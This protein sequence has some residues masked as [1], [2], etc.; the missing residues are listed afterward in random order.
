MPRRKERF[1]WLHAKQ[2][3]L[4]IA[5]AI[6]QA[7]IEFMKS[8]NLSAHTLNSCVNSQE[9][10]DRLWL[11]C[12]NIEERHVATEFNNRFLNYI[13]K[14]PL[15]MGH[16][17]LKVKRQVNLPTP[18]IR[19]PFGQSP[20]TDIGLHVVNDEWNGTLITFSYYSGR[21]FHIPHLQPIHIEKLMEEIQN[22]WK[23]EVCNC[24]QVVS[25]CCTHGCYT[26]FQLE[27]S[28][29]CGTGWKDFYLWKK[30]GYQIDY[31]S[32]F[33]IAKF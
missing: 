4:S 7:N 26:C 18:L 23:L 5:N 8:L 29:C 2:L 14:L 28:K 6:S 32:R 33:P 16:P 10:S 31:S 22:V 12:L 25:N 13:K 30:N 27:C 1:F 11:F 15:E 24:H 9:V 21:Y 20:K 19:V 17:N 3:T